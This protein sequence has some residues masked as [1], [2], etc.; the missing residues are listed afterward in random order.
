MRKKSYYT[1]TLLTGALH[2]L[3]TCN[4]WPSGSSLFTGFH[5]GSHYKII[6]WLP[7]LSQSATLFSLHHPLFF[8]SNLGELQLNRGSLWWGEETLDHFRARPKTTPSFPLLSR[9][10]FLFLYSL[11]LPISETSSFSVLVTWSV[12]CG[13]GSGRQRVTEWEGS[14]M[15][16]V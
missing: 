7:L 11:C 14:H 12:C 15:L 1:L 10:V 16:A 8:F 3:V 13:L 5:P 6:L 9:A 2:I 4:T